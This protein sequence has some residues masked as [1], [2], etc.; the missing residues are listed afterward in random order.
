M[1]LE[2]SAPSHADLTIYNAHSKEDLL[3]HAKAIAEKILATRK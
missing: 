2:F 1:D 3:S